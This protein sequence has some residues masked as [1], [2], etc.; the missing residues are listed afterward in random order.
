MMA[1][2]TLEDDTA[3]IELLAFSNVIARSGSYLKENMAIVAEGRISVRDEKA[4]QMVLN[5]AR[6]LSEVAEAAPAAQAAGH[7][8][9]RG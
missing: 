8:C 5:E 3:S 2:V 9:R 1:Y 4:P 7:R 6:P